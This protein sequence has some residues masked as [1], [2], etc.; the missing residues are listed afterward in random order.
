MRHLSH[1]YCLFSDRNRGLSAHFNLPSLRFA[2]FVQ[3]HRDTVVLYKKSC[4]QYP[5]YVHRSWAARLGISLT[6][7]LTS[8]APFCLFSD[9]NR[10]LSAHFTLPSLRFALF[11][12]GR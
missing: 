7:S 5:Q 1:S 10:V 2:L 6:G 11:V 3:G 8:C 4:V 9:R 12:Q